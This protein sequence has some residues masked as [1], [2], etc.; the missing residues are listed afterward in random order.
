M[1]WADHKAALA[2]AVTDGLGESCVFTPRTPSSTTLTGNAARTYTPGTPVTANAIVHM[3]TPEAPVMA[4]PNSK[5]TTIRREFV[6][7]LADLGFTP[8]VHTT[9]TYGGRIH[10]M[11]RPP[12]LENGDTLARCTT[13]QVGS[14]AE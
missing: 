12:Q 13:K 14:P 8:D 9:I 3:L 2:A 4:R 11:A 6:V 5:A 10:E 1:S 7:S